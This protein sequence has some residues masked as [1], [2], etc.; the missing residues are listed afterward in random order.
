MLAYRAR[1]CVHE[2]VLGWASELLL[3]SLLRDGVD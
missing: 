2:V 1:P 3:L